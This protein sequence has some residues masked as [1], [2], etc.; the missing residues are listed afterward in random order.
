MR[1]PARTNRRTG[2]GPI[3]TVLLAGALALVPLTAAPAAGA[4]GQPAPAD[5]AAGHSGAGHSAAGSC[6]GGNAPRGAAARLAAA[7]HGGSRDA[8]G[9]GRDRAPLHGV[10]HGHEPNAVS[11]AEA[12]AMDR[13]LDRRTGALRDAG[14]GGP[15]GAAPVTTVGV[16][17]HVIHDG[18]AGKLTGER[19]ADQI[20]VLNEAFNGS[21]EGN[22]PSRF[23]FRLAGT[24]Y[25]D[26]AD[27]YRGVTP[28]GAT[29]YAM[30][31]SL[32]KGGPGALNLYSAD[33]GDDLLGWATFPDAYP[34]APY[35]DGVVLL[36]ASLPGGSAEDYDE[37]DT[38]T[39]E[40]GHWLGLFH[41]FQGGCEDPGD[42]VADTPAEAVPAFE[43]PVGRDTCAADGADPVRN[44][45]DYTYDS[46]MTRFTPGQVERMS[47]AWF[48][49]RAS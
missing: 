20:T 45:M 1:I 25:T 7:P 10:G 31:S 2:R 18:A 34:E 35:L 14:R 49:Y 42:H 16:Y 19:I 32:R 11:A 44:F 28:R 43:C 9:H 23:R 26:N 47:D 36:D 12:A 13:E 17:F 4:A 6:A 3:G 24:D 46:C 5:S 30:K 29:E 39:H 40:V 27:W 33:L 37:G 38:A 22:T 15:H 48:A 21:G 8:G 41:T